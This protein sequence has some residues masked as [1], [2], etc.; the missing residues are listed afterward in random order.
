MRALILTLL[1]A[2][3]VVAQ[4]FLPARRI[5]PFAV[6]IT[7]EDS[8]CGTPTVTTGLIQ[9][10]CPEMLATCLGYTNGSLITNWPDI[11]P[12][13]TNGVYFTNLFSA[14]QAGTLRTT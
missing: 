4:V 2:L 11:S 3:P 14:S 5:A 6:S 13:R 8:S 12:V 10:L 1:V 9:R 7:C